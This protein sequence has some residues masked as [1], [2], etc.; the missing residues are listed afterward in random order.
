M[1]IKRAVSLIITAFMLLSFTACGKDKNK[2]IEDR[3][4]SEAQVYIDAGNYEQARK[5]LI[6]AV[7]E[8]PDS[9]ALAAKLIEVDELEAAQKPYIPTED[10]VKAEFLDF[11]EMYDKWF[12][13]GFFA[14]SHS[15]S[16]YKSGSETTSYII[17]ETGI[18]SKAQLDEV[19]L[20]YVTEEAYKAFAPPL[21]FYEEIDGRFCIT[22]YLGGVESLPQLD[23]DSIKINKISDND[24]EI[25]YLT[26]ESNGMDGVAKCSCFYSFTDNG[27]RLGAIN[28]EYVES[29]LEYGSYKVSTTE[30]SLK[31]RKYP[32]NSS[33]VVTTLANGAAVTVVYAYENWAYISTDDE[34]IGWVNSDFVE[35]VAGHSG[36]IG[37]IVDAGFDFVH[38]IINGL[39]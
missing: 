27:Y 30:E 16:P 6:D 25:K 24:F 32:H 33:E 35:P 3:Y 5:V 39:F 14:V 38:G 18:T 10:D 12:V 26:I 15:E 37:E 31:V 28:S 21:G 17:T 20:T 1:K 29:A 11:Y 34:P 2:E 22:V 7:V 36:T 9:D 19:F 23:P 4:L 13:K 8:L